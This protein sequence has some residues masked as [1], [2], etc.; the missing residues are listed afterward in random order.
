MQEQI[1]ENKKSI[2]WF[3][4]S[5]F[6]MFIHWGLYAAIGK[7]EWTMYG[8]KIPV[9]EYEK[10]AAT[11]NPKRFNAK[12]WVS[13]AKE[14][15]MKYIVITAKHHDGFAMFKSETEPF[16]I[17][18]STPFERDPLKEL[19]EECAIQGLKLC[20]YYSHVIDWHHPHS[21][22][23]HCNNTWDY[24]LEEKSFYNYWNRLV[25]PQITELLTQYGPIGIIWF[26]TAGGLSKKDSE[27]IVQLVKK[28]Q[29]DCLINSRV[30]HWPNFGDYQS[31][32]DNEIP[33]YGEGTKAWETPMTL[34]KSWG[35]NEQDDNYKTTESIIRKMVTIFSKGGNLLLNVGPTSLGEI[36]IPS[37]E[38]LKE[39][40]AW[41]NENGEAVYGTKESPFPYEFDWGAITVKGKKV[42]LHI[43]NNKWSTG[44]IRIN[45]F[46]SKVKKVYLLS[47][48]HLNVPFEQNSVEFV[49]LYN[50]HLNLQ[51]EPPSEFISVVVV[52]LEG[53]LQI[54]S[55]FIE[56]SGMIKLD[57]GHS[58][59]EKEHDHNVAKWKV[60][61][62]EKGK[63]EIRLITYK[64]AGTN[65]ADEFNQ[66]MILRFGNKT[67][68]VLPKEDKIVT[69]SDNCQ[70]PYSE[71]QSHLG[72]FDIE[73]IGLFSLEL[74]SN[75]IKE[76]AKG[77][78]IWQAEAVKIRTIQIIKTN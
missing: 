65:W 12:E 44:S 16:N 69:D 29:P 28:Y 32:G 10:I 77:P 60:K 25:K 63:Y 51:N 21:I 33:M 8:Q 45:G 74:G 78:E 11:F 5:R 6:G 19:A 34:N 53:E 70:Y 75:R 54:D 49:G 62:A 43:Q 55:T 40:G 66:D 3:T 37:V 7:S 76:K 38:K 30:S 64:K 67:K 72:T 23:E 31:K 22:H 42:Y 24:Q 14:A 71:V 4:E 46:K 61:I 2:D 50:L 17:V 18:D 59:I 68:N 39:I 57:L 56:Q 48:P 20:F 41:M 27:E 58:I 9:K 52:E 36:P 13:V 26:D 47:E 15:G 35:Y 73:T 1:V